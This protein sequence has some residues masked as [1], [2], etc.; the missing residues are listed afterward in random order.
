MK[1]AEQPEAEGGTA[2][3]AVVGA[4][5]GAV[6]VLLFTSARKALAGG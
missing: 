2:I 3:I 4:V 5:I 6:A 1:T